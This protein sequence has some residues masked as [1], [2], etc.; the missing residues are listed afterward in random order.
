ML[1]VI[2]NKF[3][4]RKKNLK[5]IVNEKNAKKKYLNMENTKHKF[6]W[7]ILGAYF[8]KFIKCIYTRNGYWDQKIKFSAGVYGEILLV[9][10]PIN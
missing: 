3:R 7:F 2:P 8:H 5:N 6:M 9:L 10:F 1:V 4:G